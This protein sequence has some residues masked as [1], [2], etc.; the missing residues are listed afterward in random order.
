MMEALYVRCASSLKQKF[1]FPHGTHNETWRC[2][3]YFHA[4]MGFVLE[5]RKRDAV[6]SEEST[7]RTQPTLHS[8]VKSV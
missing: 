5:A 2:Q 7:T 1:V 8:V 6:L 3:G 4:L